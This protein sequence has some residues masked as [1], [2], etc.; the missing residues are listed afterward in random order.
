[1]YCLP[2][3]L[4]AWRFSIP[5]FSSPSGNWRFL[6]EREWRI[7]N[8][9]KQSN[10]KQVFI[11]KIDDIKGLIL[12]PDAWKTTKKIIFNVGIQIQNWSVYD[13]DCI[14]IRYVQDVP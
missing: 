10:G 8:T 2:P 14:S 5:F 1:M 6:Q 3:R 13:D 7:I 12:L 11:S 9:E 4:T